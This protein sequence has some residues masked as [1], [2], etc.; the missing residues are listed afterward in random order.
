[1][2]DHESQL[3]REEMRRRTVNRSA[4]RDLRT[5]NPMARPMDRT[6]GNG[7]VYARRPRRFRLDLTAV[8]G[9]AFAVFLCASI[10]T[11]IVVL[12]GPS[13]RSE[14][15]LALAGEK[16]REA[17]VNQPLPAGQTKILLLGTDQRP[18]D[19]S[20][21]T[22][23]ILLLVLDTDQMT[24]SAVS[25]PRD[26]WVKVPDL[27]EM[28]INQVQATGGFDATAKMFQENFGVK[29]DYYVMTN[30]D[31]FTQFIDNRGGVDVEV[32]AELTDDCDLPQARDG[33]C[34]VTPGIVHMD[35][36]TALWYVRSRHTTSDLDRL[37]RE[38]EVL[39]ALFRKMINFRSVAL[40]SEMK[41]EVADNVETNISI[42][43]ALSF[44]PI[45]VRVMNS[46]DRVRH[47]A[48]GEDQATPTFSWNGMWILLPDPE[49]IRGLLQEAGIKM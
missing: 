35:G 12:R 38:Q 2:E 3:R 19:G 47:F 9:I 6:S 39:Y 7:V 40:L 20:Y 21:R 43:K 46:P 28:K 42:E 23:V 27:Y 14:T 15:S 8:L 25:F 44:L 24:V 13:H 37:R 34:T 48:I 4:N 36:A 22:D 45:A 16:G 11:L 29:P 49:A 32:G 10:I 17:I 1:M 5:S 41:G 31:G 26:L 30:F 18:N 33:D